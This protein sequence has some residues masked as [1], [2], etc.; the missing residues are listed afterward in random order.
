MHLSFSWRPPVV[1]RTRKPHNAISIRVPLVANAWISVHGPGSNATGLAE[2]GRSRGY[3]S[4]NPTGT[5]S[6]RGEMVTHKRSSVARSSIVE[7]SSADWNSYQPIE[8]ILETRPN[9]AAVTAGPEPASTA[10]RTNH[11]STEAPVR[12]PRR[13][14]PTR[15]RRSPATL[16]ARRPDRPGVLPSALSSRND[17]TYRNHPGFETVEPTGV[18]RLHAQ[19]TGESGDVRSRRR[20]AG[21]GFTEH[22]D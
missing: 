11:P 16:P 10:I 18:R 4:V 5:T 12:E 3:G 2:K 13:R 19:A 21:A 9:L 6:S 1:D 15:R 7:E 14:P 22:D 20:D 17:R 8:P